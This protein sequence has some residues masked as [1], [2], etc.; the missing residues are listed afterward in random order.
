MRSFCPATCAQRLYMLA[1]TPH[2]IVCSTRHVDSSILPCFQL[3]ASLAFSDNT[4]INL[5]FKLI[6]H[7]LQ[8]MTRVA[9]F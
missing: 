6:V 7:P 3:W 8:K 9:T 5:P 4:N 1:A 2:V